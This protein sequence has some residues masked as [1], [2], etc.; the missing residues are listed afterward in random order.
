MNIND[1]ARAGWRA[2]VL[3]LAVCGAALAQGN[4]IEAFD[5]SQQAGK[6]VVRITTREALK[7]PPPSFTVANPARIAFDF[8]GTGNALGRSSQDISQ[9]D[10]RSMN[11]V[12]AA[13]KTRLVLN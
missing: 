8:G 6:V 4:S 11:V 5:V 13:D 2:L 7:A 12:Q 3:W 9:G 1:M 10:L